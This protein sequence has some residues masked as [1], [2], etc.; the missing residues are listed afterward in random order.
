MA[1]SVGRPDT[2]FVE[3][4]KGFVGYQVFGAARPDIVF[5]TNW[6]TNIDLYWDELSAIR[7]L[8]RLGEMGRVLLIDKRGS[9]CQTTPVS[10]TSTPSRTVSTT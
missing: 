3:T 6:M 8:D 4:A 10:G 5:I 7:Y 1:T 2:R 9:G